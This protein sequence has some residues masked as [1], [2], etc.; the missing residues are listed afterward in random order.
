MNNIFKFLRERFNRLTFPQKF[1]V[2][3]VIFIFPLVAFIPLL[4]DQSTRIDHY[5]RKELFGTLYLRPLW[6]LTED[7]QTH[8]L[9][10]QKYLDGE[11]QFSDVQAAQLTID[12]DFQRLEKIHNEYS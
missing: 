9:L 7:L 5:G 6:Q 3:A 10:T 11:V 4:L 8:E 2:V 1:N 12:A